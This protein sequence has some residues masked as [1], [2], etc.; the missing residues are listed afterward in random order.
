[1]GALPTGVVTFLLT[2]VVGSTELWESAPEAMAAALARH[3]EIVEDV[4]S[5]ADGLL[6]KAR[7]EGDSSFSVF[8]RASVGVLAAYRL[9]R[10]LRNEQWPAEAGI[11]ARVAVHTGETIERDGDYYGPAVNLVA[12]LRGAAQ[13]GQ[14]LVSAPTAA[15]VRKSLPRG[16]DLVN[17][18]PLKLRGFAD[19][20]VAWELVG[21]DLEPATGAAAP[22]RP[23]SGDDHAAAG[24]AVVRADLPFGHSMG[25]TLFGRDRELEAISLFLDAPA[26]AF[27]LVEG[28]GGIGK[29]ALWQAGVALARDRGFRVLVARPVEV[30]RVLSFAALSDLLSAA[31]EEIGKLPV[32]QRRPLAAA[33]LLE[34]ASG[35]PIEPRAI[36]VGLLMLLR[37]L[38][39]TVPLLVAVDDVQWLDSPSALALSFALRRTADSSV[40]ALLAERTG[41]NTPGQ[42]DLRASLQVDR[43]AVGPLEVGAFGRLL[44]ERL[45]ARFSQPMLRRIHERAG[46]NPFFGLELAR[47]LQQRGGRISPQD[48]LPVP[49]DLKRLLEAR[50]R[51][52][53]PGLTEPL[54]AIAALG[55]PTIELVGEDTVGPAL[56][57]GVLVLDAGRIR[58]DHPLLAAAAYSRLTPGRRRALH[59]HLAEVV[60]G[61]EERARHLAAAAD[62]PDPALAAALDEA[63]RSARARGA[64]GAAAELA[65]QALRL[66]GQ[67]E[68]SALVLRSVAAAEH[69]AVAGNFGE[70][71]TMIEDLLDREPEGSN[72]ARL[73]LQRA[74]LGDQ[75]VDTVIALMEEA[76]THVDGDVALEAE[77]LAGLAHSITSARRAPDAE[78]YAKRCLELAERAGDVVL[79]V[80]A[81]EVLAT[82]QFWLGRGLPVD[83]MERALELDPLCDS[84]RISARPTGVFGWMCMW[85]GDLDRS[86]TLLAQARRVGERSADIS[87]HVVLWA[88]GELEFLADD[89][90]RSLELANEI[91]QMGVDA[92]HEPVRI[93]GLCARAVLF[94]HLGDEDATRRHVAEAFALDASHGG[95][96]AIRLGSWALALV[97]LSLDKPAAA[98]PHARPATVELRSEGLREPALLP[99]F[100]VHAEAAI[101]VGE[102]AEA[103]ELIDWAEKHAT[104][105]DRAWA[106]ACCGRCRGLAAA[107]RGDETAAVVAFE[108]ALLE[109]G[110]VQGRRFDLARTL[111]AQGETLRRFKKKRDARVS[112]EKALAIFDELGAKLWSAK[113][114]R[115]LARISGRTAT[116]GLTETEHRVAVL[117]SE[118]HSNKEVA[119][120]LFVT[121]RTVESHL[122]SIYMK[123]GV[124]S[125]TELANLLSRTQAQ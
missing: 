124:R 10:A 39:R 3:D 117:V 76:L 21:P 31:H 50:L 77:I 78:R 6:L 57:A 59:R 73:L 118:G 102:L 107:A 29:T 72:R 91:Y 42:V 100:P 90:P 81:L 32:Q 92:E 63:A 99:P 34:D 85:V 62:R 86:R 74:R 35:A 114:R 36:A 14:I 80:R 120:A 69:H 25:L 13:G 93:V 95:R 2:D 17:V 112:M 67:D 105:L 121:V 4:V 125:R 54:A 46:G 75:P 119:N 103:D 47:A 66:T 28:E 26:P 104:R 110:R 83:L 49:I 24:A 18:G 19:H 70:A 33:L 84:M 89:W 55:E 122:T 58:F 23:S 87:V 44:E 88:A 82:N 9:Q 115:E 51:A 113:A 38:A 1:M 7:G 64:P 52:L 109:H 123:L 8:N 11:R 101:A 111:L 16:C 37:E 15:I 116:R 68:R 5:A 61:A 45:A 56:D 20:V 27:A 106:L 108:R 43:I 97:E 22:P 65:T 41:G 30:E 60:D 48:D 79:L 96:T 53:P 94:A 98:L 40:R 71:R 12:R